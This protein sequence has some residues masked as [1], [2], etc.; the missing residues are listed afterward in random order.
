MKG[1][2][3]TLSSKYS[4]C[5]VHTLKSY[6]ITIHRSIYLWICELWTVLLVFFFFYWINY[7]TMSPRHTVNWFLWS[8]FY[9]IR[10]FRGKITTFREFFFFLSFKFLKWN[11]QIYK[12]TIRVNTKPATNLMNLL[13]TT[14]HMF[15]CWWQTL[16]C[17]VP[18]VH[19]L[20]NVHRNSEFPLSYQDKSKH[21]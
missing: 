16:F 18:W 2:K 7:F 1:H 11:L 13:S 15:V 14:N 6:I 4:K 20:F 9:C 19:W 21:M 10:T 12:C 5:T 8:S 17:S 3:R